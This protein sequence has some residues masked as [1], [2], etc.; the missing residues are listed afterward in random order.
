MIITLK[1]FV[2]MVKEFDLRCTTDQQVKL[3]PI[4]RV[5]KFSSRELKQVFNGQNS[6]KM[7][8]F[9]PAPSLAE[10]VFLSCL[11]DEDKTIWNTVPTGLGP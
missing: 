10:M 11:Q 7:D 5:K 1:D 3:E 6:S 9:C 2:A 4:H 8:M